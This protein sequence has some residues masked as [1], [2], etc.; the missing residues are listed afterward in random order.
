MGRIDKLDT[1]ER[2]RSFHRVFALQNAASVTSL[3]LTTEVL[4]AGRTKGKNESK[5]ETLIVD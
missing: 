4:I 1:R 2:D 3:M 5:G